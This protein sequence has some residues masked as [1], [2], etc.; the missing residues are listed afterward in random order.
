MNQLEKN[1]R[2]ELVLK[3]TSY[4]ANALWEVFDEMTTLLK[5][6]IAV[7]IRPCKYNFQLNHVLNTVQV[8]KG[9]EMGCFIQSILPHLKGR[10][11]L[12]CETLD[13]GHM[14]KWSTC[15]SVGAGD[16]YYVLLLV[17]EFSIF[18]YPFLLLCMAAHS[19][20]NHFLCLKK[21]WKHSW[22]KASWI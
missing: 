17:T 18:P 21:R 12:K 10:L 9:G 14:E 4:L 3:T 13:I 19:S 16:L 8:K 1:R 20:G 7:A 2:T 22:M 5:T 6:W 11:T 15:R